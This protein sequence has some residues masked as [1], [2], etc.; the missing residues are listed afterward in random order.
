MTLYQLGKDYLRQADDLKGVIERYSALKNTSSGIELYEIN[1][2][3][4]VLKEMERDMRITGKQLMEYYNNKS[5][6]KHYCSHKFN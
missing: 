5:T 2:K 3:I 4:V 1:S 6:K